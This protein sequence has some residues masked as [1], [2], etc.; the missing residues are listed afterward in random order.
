[1][2]SW[3]STDDDGIENIRES[4]VTCFSPTLG[5]RAPDN[6]RGTYNL[7]SF[8]FDT[9]VADCV[10]WREFIADN[11]SVL[12][13]AYSTADIHRAKRE[14]KSAVLLNFQNAPIGDRLE[15]LD[16]FHGLGV[17]SMQLTYN[18]RNLLGDGCT[19]RTNAGLSDFGVAAVQRMN[20]LGIVVDTSHSG[21]QT[22]LDAIEFM[23]LKNHELEPEW[24]DF[25]GRLG[26]ADKPALVQLSAKVVN[27]IDTSRDLRAVLKKFKRDDLLE[28]I[29]PEDEA[30]GDH[31][32]FVFSNANARQIAEVID[33]L[34]VDHFDDN[35][36]YLMRVEH[37]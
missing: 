25:W 36:A 22:T 28:L 8:P 30:D 23:V 24:T 17:R 35:R 34:F 5:W 29:E 1:M 14:G 31:P 27:P 20:E 26:E 19:E 10:T 16:M 21:Y 12:A 2:I 6:P 32:L 37:A 3:E 4:G 15:N 13:A 18:E 33:L 9:A 7:Q 11:E